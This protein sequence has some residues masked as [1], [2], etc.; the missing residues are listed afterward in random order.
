MENLIYRD[1]PCSSYC[2]L[3][4]RY[5]IVTQMHEYIYYILDDLN[6]AVLEKNNRIYFI[7]KNCSKGLNTHFANLLIFSENNSLEILQFC[8]QSLN[9]NKFILIKVDKFYIKACSQYNLKHEG[10]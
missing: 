2:W 9:N 5:A 10:Y 4:N 6:M 3:A 8:E 1:I 7:G